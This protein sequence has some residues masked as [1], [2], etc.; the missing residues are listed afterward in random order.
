M[1]KRPIVR[2]FKYSILCLGI[3][4][5]VA[6]LI[7]TSRSV[8]LGLAQ[9]ERF[10]DH[11]PASHWV[12]ALGDPDVK[13]REQAS[14]ALVRIAPELDGAVPA[15]TRGLHDQDDLVRAQC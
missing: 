7:P 4:L 13:V 11:M 3:A 15:L 6:L 9:N 1:K 12:K 10:E 5:S 8:L 14:L 2:S